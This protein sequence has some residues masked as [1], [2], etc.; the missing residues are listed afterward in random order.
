[1]TEKLLISAIFGEADLEWFDAGRKYHK[2]ETICEQRVR[3][4]NRVKRPGAK[5]GE[6]HTI[7]FDISELTPDAPIPD[8][9]KELFM[10]FASQVPVPDVTLVSRF[11]LIE[12]QAKNAADAARIIAGHLRAAEDQGWKTG[13]ARALVDDWRNEYELTR[14]NEK[15]VMQ[16]DM[17]PCLAS[18]SPLN[19]TVHTL[20]VTKPTGEQTLPNFEGTSDVS[21]SA[22]ARSR[23]PGN[24]LLRKQF[25]YMFFAVMLITLSGIAA[26]GY[27]SI[28]L[29]MLGIAAFGL[30]LARDR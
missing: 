22:R 30:W 12:V 24:G 4:G 14:E 27:R 13:D 15:T 18:D 6:T 9:V 20:M 17:R 5:P 1:M 2:N 26:E 7:F 16:F 25:R 23:L 21:R 29:A 10:R 8:A 19:L 3:L 11:P 28:A